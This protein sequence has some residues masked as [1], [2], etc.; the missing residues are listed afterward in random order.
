MG[1]GT[2]YLI[3]A[4]SAVPDECI[5]TAWDTEGQLQMR[6]QYSCT[7]FEFVLL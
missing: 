7:V 2:V 4:A 5:E 1:A 6:F 3:S